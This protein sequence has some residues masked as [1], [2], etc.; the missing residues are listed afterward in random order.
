MKDKTCCFTGHRTIRPDDLEMLTRNTRNAVCEL[1]DR[2]YTCFIVGGAIGYDTLA[3]RILL[4]LR[5]TTCPYI[6]VILAYPFEGYTASWEPVQQDEHKR[7]LPQFDEAVCVSQQAS[8]GAYLTR[9][10]YMVDH[11]SVCVSY[12]F[13]KSGGTAYTVR[14]AHEKG[15]T[16]VNAI[17]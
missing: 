2:G 4:D 7:L 14:Y 1:I 5:D 15:V 11:S 8:R 12:C 6:R 16:V 9:N 13:R 10:R 17:T 3:A